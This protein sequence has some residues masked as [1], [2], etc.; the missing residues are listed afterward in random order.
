MSEFR[1]LVVAFF[2]HSRIYGAEPYAAEGD[3]VERYDGLVARGRC[4]ALLRRGTYGGDR[5]VAINGMARE[6]F[7]ADTNLRRAVFGAWNHLWP[8]DAPVTEWLWE[9]APAAGVTA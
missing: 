1:W 4:V 5:L 7:E 6:D 2:P 8:I 3:A 9:R